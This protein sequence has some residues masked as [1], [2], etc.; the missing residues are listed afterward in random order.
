[1]TEEAWLEISVDGRPASQRSVG[2]RSSNP[3]LESVYIQGLGNSVDQDSLLP[4]FRSIKLIFNYDFSPHLP[5]SN[6]FRLSAKM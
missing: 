4:T 3:Q 6:I 1:M 2:L 5:N